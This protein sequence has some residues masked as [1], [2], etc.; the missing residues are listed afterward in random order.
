MILCREESSRSKIEGK[1]ILQKSARDSKGSFG[2]FLRL[3]TDLGAL[4][5]TFNLTSFSS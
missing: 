1:T 4:R 2:K 3:L 5:K